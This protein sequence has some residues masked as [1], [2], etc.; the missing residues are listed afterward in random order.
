[1]PQENAA[2]VNSPGHKRFRNITSKSLCMSRKWPPLRNQK[3]RRSAIKSERSDRGRMN[4]H[5]LPLKT[6][7]SGFFL[8]F[9]E[10]SVF[11]KKQM[12]RIPG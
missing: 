7:D 6:I 4:A 2:E 9:A 1:M 8:S 11:F 12:S 3:S 5:R 10:I